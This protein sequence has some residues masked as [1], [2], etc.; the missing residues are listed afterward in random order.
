[1]HLLHMCT[2]LVH[3][4]KHLQEKTFREQNLSFPFNNSSPDRDH[5]LHCVI[6]AV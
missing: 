5:G 6:V 2:Q 3:V 4:S 1:M